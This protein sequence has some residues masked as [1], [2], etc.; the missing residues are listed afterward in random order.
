MRAA[1]LTITPD[2]RE[3]LAP[4]LGGDRRA[5][6]AELQK[7]ILYVHGKNRIELDDVLAVVTDASSQELDALVD[8]AFSGAKEGT[9]REFAKAAIARISAAAIIGAALRHAERLHVLRLDVEAGSSISSLVERPQSGIHFRRK[10][11]F[12]K[13]LRVWT[14]ERLGRVISILAQAS[15]EA[16]VQSNLSETIAQ[17]ALMLIARGAGRREDNL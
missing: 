1:D 6:R 11:A 17:R 2:A 9:E 7:L 16:R 15:F 14:S 3:A 13:A 8:A 12:E 5:S 4:L 10:A